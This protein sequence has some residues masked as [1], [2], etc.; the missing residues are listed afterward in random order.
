M[1]VGERSGIPTITACPSSAEA[2][3]RRAEK[4]YIRTLLR[5]YARGA[6]DGKQSEG[7][8]CDAAYSSMR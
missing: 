4:I 2:V 5:N 1:R 3:G 7:V 6:R 8:I